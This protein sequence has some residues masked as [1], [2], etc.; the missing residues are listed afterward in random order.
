MKFPRKDYPQY[1]I[2][3]APNPYKLEKLL[4]ECLELGWEPIGGAYTDGISHYWSMKREQEIKEALDK[5][6]RK[7]L[8]E[9]K[10]KKVTY[11]VV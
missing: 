5:Q 8:T 11:D 4:V 3:H 1:Q 6:I 9:K 10:R 7:A 2:I